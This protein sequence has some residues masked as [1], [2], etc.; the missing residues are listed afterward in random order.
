MTRRS[1]FVLL[2]SV[3]FTGFCA[4]MSWRFTGLPLLTL[5]VVGLHLALN[6]D[7]IRAS[8]RSVFVVSA[9]VKGRRRHGWGLSP[10]ETLRRA[11]WMG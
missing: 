7:R 10:A 3:L 5:I 8:L 9:D 1:A 6:W 4:V 11:G 2:D